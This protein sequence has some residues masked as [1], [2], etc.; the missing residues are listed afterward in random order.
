MAILVLVLVSL[1]ALRA[2][3]TIE[4]A[5]GESMD[6]VGD[7]GTAKTSRPSVEEH[8]PRSARP[9]LRSS[10]ERATF[11]PPPR[12]SAM[13][14][15]RPAARWIVIAVLWAAFMFPLYWTATTAL[16]PAPEWTPIGHVFWAPENPTLANFEEVLGLGASQYSRPDAIG[17]LKNS[18]VAATGGT[19][20]AVFVGTLAAYGMGRFRAG[21]RL[22]AFQ[23]LQLRMLPPIAIMIPLLVFFAYVGLTDKLHGLVIAYAAIT[24]PFAL[25]LM[26]SFFEEVPREISEAAIADGCTHWGALVKTVLPQVKGG[27]AA[28]ALFLFILNWSDFLIAFTLSTQELV[29]APMQ[30]NVM[31]TVAP[32]RRFGPE[33]ALAI[34]LVLPPALFGLVIQRYLVRGLTFG[35]VTR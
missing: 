7:R 14:R 25:W 5:Q 30:L 28:T 35:A 12:R 9:E 2:V 32:A 17:P 1:A 21:G 16:K 15:A 29:T 23:I 22:F 18:L 6:L 24:F 3:R 31:Q 13:R 34:V 27:L 11:I 10:G 33:S 26:R 20:L 19:L 8:Q 4:R